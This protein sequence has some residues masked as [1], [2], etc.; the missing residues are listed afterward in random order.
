MRL[1]QSKIQKI[2]T[3]A[4]AAQGFLIFVAGCLTLAIMTSAKTDGRTD[5]FFALCFLTMP[6]FIYLIGVPMWSRTVRFASA[7]GFAL[8]D[9]LYTVFWFAAFIC[10]A[11]WNSEGMK[12]GAEEV[13]ASSGNCS[14]FAY[15]S[16]TKCKLSK[17]TVGFGVIIFLLFLLTT[18]ISFYYISVY[19]R[20]GV[21]PGTSESPD[22][23]PATDNAT[24]F[25]GPTA[26]EPTSKFDTENVWSAE[27]NDIETASSHYDHHDPNDFGADVPPVPAIPHNHAGTASPPPP[28]PAAALGGPVP[29][30]TSTLQ[31]G[32]SSLVDMDRLANTPS[33]GPGPHPQHPGRQVSW[34]A[35]DD[36]ETFGANH[37]AYRPTAGEEYES[38]R[39]HLQS[40]EPFHIAPSALSPATEYEE[41]TRPQ[42]PYE[43]RD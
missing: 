18:V 24:Y 20:T 19:R 26:Y 5:Y 37:P 22:H 21:L 17:A 32:Y 34:G 27:T 6:A 13:N 3:A 38:Q 14:T 40:P 9:G 35:G 39:L 41:Y 28:P 1:E 23:I 8:L 36:S 33:P 30:R 43:F 29:G 2:K 7:Y 31:A 15:G 11:T 12:K 16:D 25:G 10:V 4:H 42:R